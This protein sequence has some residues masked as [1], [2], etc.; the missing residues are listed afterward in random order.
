MKNQFA[1]LLNGFQQLDL[2]MRELAP[3]KTLKTTPTDTIPIR[4]AP[5]GRPP[6][7]ALPSEYDGDRLKGQAFLISCQ[8]YMCLCPD[9]FPEEQTKITWTLSYMKSGWAAK[10]AER[11]FYWEEKN[12]G[13]SKFLD[14]DE[15][16]NGFRKDFCPAHSNVAAI[17]KLESTTYY[18]KSQSI[19]DYLDEF[20]ELVAEVGYT[21]PK[22]VVVKFWKG[23]DPQIQN[24]ITTMAYG[25]PS[26]ASL[27]SWYEAAKNVDQNRMANEAFKSAYQAPASTPTRLTSIPLCPI[28]QSQSRAPPSAYIHPTLSTSVPIDIDS[29]GKKDP[30][31]MTCYR[32]CQLGHKAPDCPSRFDIRLLTN[33][34]LENKLMNR[35]DIPPAE[36]LLTEIEFEAPKEKDFVQDNEWK[37]RPHCPLIT[38]WSISKYIWFRNVSLRHAKTWRTP[39][40]RLNSDSVTVRGQFPNRPTLQ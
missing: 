18:Q 2:L 30:T 35:R 4:L 23:L 33:E 3:A 6:P 8:T 9:S 13:Y 12:P 21:D 7:P 40:S 5:T 32:C 34:E 38:A 1:A 36:I 22:I 15:F 28:Q 11:I 31:P 37:A 19:N 24:T 10:W 39:D 27:E 26:N 14:W 20:V 29:S 17:N 16:Q 25:R